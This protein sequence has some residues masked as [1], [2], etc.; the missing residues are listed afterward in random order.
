MPR[1]WPPVTPLAVSKAQASRRATLARI[2]PAPARMKPRPGSVP[3]V[4]AV[5]A[6]P[7]PL[8]HCG[9]HAAHQ[10]LAARRRLRRRVV[11]VRWL[12]SVRPFNIMRNYAQHIARAPCCPARA[13]I[14][15]I[16]C[17][18]PQGKGLIPP[19]A[20]RVAARGA[21]AARAACAPRARAVLPVRPP[22][23]S[24]RLTSRPACGS[25]CPEWDR[26]AGSPSTSRCGSVSRS[27]R[28]G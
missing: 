2:R 11:C 18:W 5:P 10:A 28:A 14:I 20:R 12:Q 26:G 16:M 3:S 24:P 6:N 8:R 23:G 19:P 1:S 7:P 21:S 27:P 13:R 4:G 17:K 15:C 22:R 25:S 9:L